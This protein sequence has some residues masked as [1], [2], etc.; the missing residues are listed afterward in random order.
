MIL[1]SP[2]A[3][4]QLGQLLL[5]KGVSA[6]THGLRLQ[7]QKGGCAGLRYDMRVDQILPTD[8]VIRTLLGNRVLVDAVSAPF[9]KGCELDYVDTL[10]EQ[11]FRVVNPQAARS[12]GCGTS[13]EMAAPPTENLPQGEECK[14]SAVAT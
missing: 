10:S 4:D 5:K 11:G 2:A 6:E 9:L 8:T 7:I 14:T 12:C 13:F 3:A 1:V